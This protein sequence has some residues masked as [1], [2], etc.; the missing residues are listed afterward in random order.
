MSPRP[1]RSTRIYTLFPNTTLFRSEAAVVDYADGLGFAHGLRVHRGDGYWDARRR[2]AHRQFRRAYHDRRQRLLILW[3]LGGIVA[4]G[5]SRNVL[6]GN[7]LLRWLAWQRVLGKRRCGG[8]RDQ[9]NERYRR[10]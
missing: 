2:L 7:A 4:D 9:P 3:A 1:P 6:C 10:C 5:R 8:Q